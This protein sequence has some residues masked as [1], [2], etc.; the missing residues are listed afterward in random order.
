MQAIQDTPQS[1]PSAPAR[2]AWGT[3][4]V[5]VIAYGVLM[6][7][8]LILRIAELDAVPMNDVEASRALAT[9]HTLAPEAP[10]AIGVTSAPGEVAPPDS[11]VVYW[12]QR[13]GFALLGANEFAAR[14]LTVLAG[15]A[16][17]LTPLLFR[18]TL[19]VGRAFLASLLLALSPIA[20][21]VARL[22]EPAIWAALFALLFLSL[23]ER[24]WT[25]PTALH[26]YGFALSLGALLFLT[27][28][29][30]F[31]LGVI[32]LLSVGLTALWTLFS[33]D[34]IED[35]AANERESDGNANLAQ[36]T[37]Q[38][39][40]AF[41]W[42][43]AV[44]AV[45][46]LIVVVS[47]GFMLYPAG[48]NMVAEVIGDAFTG[49]TR[50]SESGNLYV[51]PLQVLLVY[52][53]WLVLIA[54]AGG[55][56]LWRSRFADARTH[57]LYIWTLVTLIV[58]AI[59]PGAGPS[60]ALWLMLPLVAFASAALNELFVHYRA[61]VF[62][63]DS[64]YD[65]DD[66]LAPRYGW[67]KWLLGALV[68]G[69]L[70]MLAVHVQEVARHLMTLPGD[71]VGGEALSL[72]L[73]PRYL[74]LRYSAI[75]TAIT[76]LLFV[77]GALLAA[78]IWGNANTL[79]GVGMGLL[80]FLLLTNVATGWNT[81][82]V[83]ATNPAE[84]WHIRAPH[85]DAYLLRETLQEIAAR[86]TRDQPV[87]PITVLTDAN[88]GLRADGL[89][90]WLLRDFTEARY[91]SSLADVARDEIALL[92]AS[93]EAPDLGGSYVGQ[94]FALRHRWNPTTLR[95]VDVPAWWF[96]RR[97]RGDTLMQETVILWLRVDVYDNVPAEERLQG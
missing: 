95:G 37:R 58:I 25:Q 32:V 66:A 43:N 22:S 27:S 86:D 6:A 79:Q 38:W 52:E 15:V 92:P 93:L 11:P 88:Q 29:A 20:F 46:L 85:P 77:V 12:A 54:L 45:L 2:L 3:L 65:D 78:S 80:G 9:W 7:L 91:V 53:P 41:P 87:I 4:S 75:W 10:G 17:S 94:S 5:E 70:L 64:V 51:F 18:A 34:R 82:V 89:L 67:V 23:L 57:F 56:W 39:L 72:L 50:A 33:P 30:G 49:M 1:T 63:F 48:L 16:L 81:A 47:T 71:N 55:V 36:M 24:A 42:L 59:Y 8:A 14:I 28:G 21:T 40:S 19:G 68:L 76:A 44:G 31:V 62:W 83:N 73:E 60:Q 69:L 96:Q 61:L 26:R 35:R 97:L 74:E 90:G 84:L 13:L